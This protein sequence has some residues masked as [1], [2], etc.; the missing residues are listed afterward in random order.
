[1]CGASN[2]RQTR[3]CYGSPT[4]LERAAFDFTAEITDISQRSRRKKV[5]V[6]AAAP[7]KARSTICLSWPVRSG[8]DSLPGASTR[9]ARAGRESVVRAVPGPCARLHP[10][11]RGCWLP[12][13]ERPHENPE[14]ASGTEFRT[15]LRGS[16]AVRWVRGRS[17]R[18]MAN[19][20]TARETL[21]ARKAPPMQA[22]RHTDLPRPAQR[23]SAAE[24]SP[25]CASRIR[26]VRAILR[27][28][29][30]EARESRAR[31]AIPLKPDRAWQS[32]VQVLRRPVRVLDR[33]RNARLPQ[34][35]S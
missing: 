20:M 33:A 17:H 29:R 35:R 24:E 6:I 31:R 14:E 12:M 28:Q 22:L 26:K 18:L 1:M 19:Q 13:Q 23:R 8:G 10:Q 7:R 3:T 21:R 4:V 11:F 16:A 2:G 5:A 25:A 34:A 15:E 27:S 32:R 9:P 30:V